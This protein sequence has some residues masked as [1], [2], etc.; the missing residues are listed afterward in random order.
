MRTQA[1]HVQGNVMTV[2]GTVMAC[3][4]ALTQHS[5]TAIEINLKITSVR[6]AGVLAS[7]NRTPCE[8][9]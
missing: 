9:K 2:E 1:I 7:L 4:K 6:V 8:Y 3:V 5:R